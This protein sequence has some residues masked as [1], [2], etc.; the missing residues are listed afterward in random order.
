MPFKYLGIPMT[1]RRLRNS[2]WQG[3]V[4]RF[5]KRLSTW[6]AKF[7]SSGGRL[8]LLNYVFSSLPIFMMSFF[9]IPVDVLKKLDDIRS[10][11]FWQGGVSKRKYRLARWNIVCQ[12]KAIGGLGVSNLA[13]KNISLLSK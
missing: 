12:P 8:V 10:R 5:K 1:H 6:T 9:E 7:L 3:V 4:D 11:F 13:V 2:D